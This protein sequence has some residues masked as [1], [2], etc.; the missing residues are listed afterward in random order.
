M[1]EVK[2][3]L[4]RVWAEERINFGG[5]DGRGSQIRRNMKVQQA[6]MASLASSK[7]RITTSCLS[8]GLGREP[9]PSTYSPGCCSWVSVEGRKTYCVF[10]AVVCVSFEEV[11]R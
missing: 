8:L 7:G 6:A 5:D 4:A 3:D 2:F 11:Y 1:Q 9:T 10:L